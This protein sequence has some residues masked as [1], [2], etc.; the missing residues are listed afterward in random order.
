MFVIARDF[1]K[2]ISDVTL[3]IQLEIDPETGQVQLVGV[4]ATRGRGQLAVWVGQTVVDVVDGYNCK[5]ILSIHNAKLQ[6][7]HESPK[8][9]WLL[10]TFSTVEH[11][12]RD[13]FGFISSKQLK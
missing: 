8:V 10:L 7:I 3:N 5:K 2:R 1:K 13:G 12:F 6:S 4:G 9:S 11:L